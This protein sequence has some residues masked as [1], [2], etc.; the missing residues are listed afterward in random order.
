[1]TLRDVD[2][3]QF[4]YIIAEQVGVS[5]HRRTR[6]TQR[7]SITEETSSNAAKSEFDSA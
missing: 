3:H 4:Y 7:Y 5:I 1:M 2:V 6:V